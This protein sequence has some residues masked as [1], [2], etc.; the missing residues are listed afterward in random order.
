[1][2]F[3][4]SLTVNWI[5]QPINLHPQQDN[6]FHATVP[7]TGR[8]FPFFPLLNHSKHTLSILNGLNLPEKYVGSQ[9][10]DL[11]FSETFDR[12]QIASDAV[13]NVR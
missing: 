6:G 2:D 12:V 9:F 11:I 7:I 3:H 5:S 13:E 1:M 4:H 8:L 10:Q